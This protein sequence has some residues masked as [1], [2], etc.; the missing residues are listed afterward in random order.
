M[1]R[2]ERAT[3]ALSTEEADLLDSMRSTTPRGTYLRQL[4]NAEVA[5]WRSDQ[6]CS[7]MLDSML[8]VRARHR[9]EAAD[10][11][12]ARRAAFTV[13]RDA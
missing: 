3:V 13:V 10:S 12:E 5:R 7:E 11:P 9:E 6:V 8:A 1:R 4:L 2:E